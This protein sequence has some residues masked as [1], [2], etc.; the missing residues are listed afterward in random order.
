VFMIVVP[1]I[2]VLAY[3]IAQHDGNRHF[4]VYM[5]MESQ[6]SEPTQVLDGQ[7]SLTP[8]FDDSRVL[9]NNELPARLR[10][11]VTSTR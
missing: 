8:V 5:A 4:V 9:S 6:G 2:G 11:A 7:E 10:Q 3:L 1:F